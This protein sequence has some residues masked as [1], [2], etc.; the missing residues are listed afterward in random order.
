MEGSGSVKIITDPGGP[1]TCQCQPCA[2]RWG[3]EEEKAYLSGMCRWKN[4]KTDQSAICLQQE[5]TQ[6]VLR[7]RIRIWIR[8]H[9]S[10]IRIRIRLRILLSSCKNVLC[11][12]Y[13]FWYLKNDVNAA[14]K[15]NRLKT[16]KKK[17]FLVAILQVT[18]DNSRIRSRIR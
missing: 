9:L 8:I 12:L 5:R 18:V 10:E 6:T 7:I 1:K 4:S 16:K 3:V 15:S 14:S 11:L 13:D 2:S 17:I